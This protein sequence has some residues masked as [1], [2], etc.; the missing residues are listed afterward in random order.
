MTE[1]Y[2][3]LWKGKITSVGSGG[4]VLNVCS[5][6]KCD[7]FLWIDPDVAIN[8]G[9][10]LRGKEYIEAD[11]E[12]LFIGKWVEGIP[13]LHIKTFDD[14]EEVVKLIAKRVK[15]YLEGRTLVLTYSG[16]K[17]STAALIISLKLQEYIDFKLRVMYVFMPYL[18]ALRNIKFV[19]FVSKRLGINIEVVEPKRRYVKKM[20]RW[21]GLPRRGNR[22]CTYFKVRPIRKVVRGNPNVIEGVADRI[23]ESPKRALRLLKRLKDGFIA[24]KKKFT[25]VE[26]M[27]IIDIMDIVRK[28]DLIHP[29]Y[30][31]GLP[32]V[33]CSL[34][35]YKTLY[36]FNVR[37]DIED[38][39]FIEEVLR[40]EH[41]KGKVYSRIPLEDFLEHALWRFKPITAYR[42]Y[43]LKNILRRYVG[44]LDALSFQ[45][46][47]SMHEKSWSG[48]AMLKNKARKVSLEELVNKVEVSLNLLG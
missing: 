2:P 3:L 4:D 34:C 33:S 46:V 27:P 47:L 26:F 25:P 9:R 45:E 18:E 21:L 29:A 43:K 28:Y 32:R 44:D 35:P 24:S 30:K 5:E 12:R 40:K 1:F 19:D 22:W 14:L 11:H 6:G 15:T 37:E 7:L 39:G 42:L 41:S 20:L 8:I 38:E 23:F 13:Y 10:F 48:V 31:D 17:D 16:G 36:E